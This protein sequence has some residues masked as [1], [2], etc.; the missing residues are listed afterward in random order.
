MDFKKKLLDNAPS[1]AFF[2]HRSRVQKLYRGFLRVCDNKDE[3]RQVREE[4][5]RTKTINQLALKEAEASLKRLQLARGNNKGT[6]LD[7]SHR[8]LDEQQQETS[9][10]EWPWQRPNASNN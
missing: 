5:I 9:K 8:P 10:V 2:I 7:Q 3:R 4:F 1:V 6:P